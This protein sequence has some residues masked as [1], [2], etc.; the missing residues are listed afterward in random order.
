MSATPTHRGAL[1]DATRRWLV[2]LA[3]STVRSALDD[4]ELHLPDPADVPPDAAR[5]GAAFVTLRRDGRLLGCIGSLEPV[6][7]LA[8]DVAAHAYDA[9]FR[10]PRLPPVTLD[11]WLRMDVEVSVLGPLEPIDVHS[12]EELMAA[13]RP[14]ID[15]VLLTS[16]EG[17]GTFLPSVWAQVPSPDRFL[18]ELWRKAGLRRGRWPKDLVVQRYQVDEFGD[19]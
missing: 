6:R 4:G 16:K 13:V 15:G 1:A 5:P 3:R 17:R 11:D 9:A 18:D 8:D 7:S 14:D 2:A 19:A 10:D 12:R